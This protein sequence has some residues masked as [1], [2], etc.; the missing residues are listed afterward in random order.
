MNTRAATAVAATLTGLCVTA[1]A[2][3]RALPPPWSVEQ[4]KLSYF[5]ARSDRYSTLF[6][7]TSGIY[8]QIVVSEFDQAM[9][10]AGHESLSFNFGEDA[11]AV[12]EVVDLAQRV[13]ALRPASLQFVFIDVSL[14]DDFDDE[15]PLTVR[16]AAWHEPSP[17]LIVIESEL[18]ASN[19]WGELYHRLHYDGTGISY[20][21]LNIGRGSFAVGRF[22]LSKS[23]WWE[24]KPVAD[25]GYTSL[26][27]YEDPD[28]I[29]AHE[30]LLLTPQKYLDK[31]RDMG[32][33]PPQ[34]GP[35]RYLKVAIL[36]YLTDL[37]RARGVTPVLL[38]TPMLFA[39]VLPFSET[40]PP[41]FL[42]FTDAKKL[43]QLF[44]IENRFDMHHLNDAG[45][46]LFTRLLAQTFLEH[47]PSGAR[48][49]AVH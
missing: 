3:H 49:N 41:L 37:F 8:H 9:R 46:R 35:A 1:F 40:R 25:E 2:L 33:A 30:E 21:V 13:L 16:Q 43:P 48:T 47:L 32:F 39:R 44:A 6:L 26:A 36:H 34:S 38:Q 24:P 10:A 42:D 28:V 27:G 20:N 45:S 14:F 11:L 5:A 4:A 12:G 15:N 31:V 19:D 29:A 22:L 18:D 7:G 23:S 17:T